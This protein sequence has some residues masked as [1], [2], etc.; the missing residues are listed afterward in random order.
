[1]R[2]ETIRL[3]VPREVAKRFK[4]ASPEQRE[5][6]SS[7]V[8]RVLMS[9]DEAAEEFSRIATNLSHE[10]QERGVTESGLDEMRGQASGLVLVGGGVGASNGGGVG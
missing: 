5:R 9:A 2:T 4:D 1:M 7:V 3:K 10:A 8:A 6:A